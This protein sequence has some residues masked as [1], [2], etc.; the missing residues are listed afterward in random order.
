MCCTLR[1]R[2]PVP[3]PM[4]SVAMGGQLLLDRTAQICTGF[5]KESPECPAVSSRAIGHMA[6]WDRGPVGSVACRC[7]I[8]SR[9]RNLLAV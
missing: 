3:Q 4:C 1:A 7:K 5:E 2:L 9:F 6:G 8:E